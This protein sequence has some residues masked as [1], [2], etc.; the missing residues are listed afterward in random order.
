MSFSCRIYFSR[1][2]D[3]SRRVSFTCRTAFGSANGEDFRSGSFFL[4]FEE[5][6][7]RTQCLIP[8]FDDANRE[9][10]ETFDVTLG[11]PV[12]VLL[13]SPSTT[14]VTI[15]DPEDGIWGYD[16]MPN[17]FL[18]TIARSRVWFRS[19]QSSDQ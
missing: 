13:F 11:N 7:T 15:I 6:E 4:S 1:H 5:G 18:I 2:G 17:L 9:G 19:G 16:K 3:T 10:E 12:Q 14:V 8:L